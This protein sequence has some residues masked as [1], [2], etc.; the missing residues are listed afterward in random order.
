MLKPFPIQF[1][2][3]EVSNC[4]F[5]NFAKMMQLSTSLPNCLKHLTSAW[6]AM[7]MA[8][9]QPCHLQKSH[10]QKSLGHTSPVMS[11]KCLATKGC[12]WCCQ[13]WVPAVV[14]PE[15][16]AKNI[17]SHPGIHRGKAQSQEACIRWQQWEHWRHRHDSKSNSCHP[18]RCHLS[19]QAHISPCSLTGGHMHPLRRLWTLPHHLSNLKS[20]SGN[21]LSSQQV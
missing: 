3:M 1:I 5:S 17:S 15:Q 4:T 18:H 8:Q 6:A 20:S 12:M 9:R 13:I 2:M 11:F 16:P 19:P 10:L 21:H 14:Y 7:P